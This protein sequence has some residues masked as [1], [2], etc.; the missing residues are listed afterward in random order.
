[1][2]HK[3]K[4]I[5][6]ASV[7]ACLSL[8]GC[9]KDF[10]DV[11]DDP[12]RVT[13]ANINPELI[14]PAAAEGAGATLIGARAT[15]AGATT[16]TQFAYD[17]VGYMAGNGDFA[18]NN[19]ETT[20]NIDFN[21][22]DV[23]FQTWY[24]VLFDLHQAAVKGLPAGDTAVTGAS[25]VL[26]A[27]IF[28]DLTDLFGN[29]PYSQAFKSDSITRP[30]YDQAQDIYKSLQLQLDSAK[31]YLGFNAPSKFITVDIVNSG[32]MTKWIKLANTLKLRLL[33][34]QSKV[35]GLDPSAELAKIFDPAG[36]GILGAGESVSVNPGYVNDLNKQSPFYANF[37]YTTTG[38]KAAPG[39]SANDFIVSLLT[40]TNDPRLAR[41]FNPVTCGS[42]DFVGNV[43]GDDAGNL[44]PGNKTSY[45]G[46]ALI[47]NLSAVCTATGA[48]ASESQW[49][50]PS[51][52]SLFFKAEAIALGWL[53]GQGTA[54]D[55]YEAAVTESF[56]W[57]GVPDAATA[58]AAYL[59]SAT[60]VANFDN[61]GTTPESQDKFIA[62]QKYLAN[63]C[64]DPL[65][66]YADLRRIPN[67]LPAG[68][69]SVNTG[70]V[71]GTV[72]VR[73]LYPQSE[74]TTNATNVLAQGTINA[75]TSKLF[76][77]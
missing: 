20:Y 55:A 40:N 19:T 42:N 71:S 33:I 24:G 25:M 66:S 56:V 72:P 16:G 4:Y 6:F 74:Y 44:F 63:T 34:R 10:L 69:I 18:R 60:T 49:L 68:Y 32:D 64:V 57:T 5:L 27:K 38:A 26:S 73:L 31:Y 53:T 2:R 1:M 58:A 36:P 9:K 23:L 28:Q 12:N 29:I 35:S 41:F 61:A 15:G 54:K 17:W 39:V 30:A 3:I 45:F 67:L 46:P 21:F 75:F 70:K 14:F 76:W 50:M 7:I 59:S 37:G 43:Y 65:E 62:F 8:T 51:Y 11:N 52:E 77:Q 22:A 13:D 47:G 48:G